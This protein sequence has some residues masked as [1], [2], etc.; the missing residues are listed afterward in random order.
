[1][2]DKDL[3]L[4]IIITTLSIFSLILIVII[5]L[6]SSYR[7]RLKQQIRFSNM[8]LHYEQ[9]LRTVEQEVQ[10]S[11]MNHIS[12]ELHDNIGQLLTLMRVQI[13]KGKKQSDETATALIPISKTLTD[14]TKQIRL[15]SHA[16]NSEYLER[17]GLRETIAQEVIRLQQLDDIVVHFDTDG[18]EPGLSK[19]QC[20]MAFRIFQEMLNNTLKH[21]HAQN[22]YILLE[23]EKHFLLQVRDDGRGFDA[24]GMTPEE[25]GNGLKN[26]QKRARLAGLGF[27]LQSAPGAGCTY[28]IEHPV[29]A[30]NEAP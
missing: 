3:A 4:A 18:T 26:M 17:N 24:T 28:A 12:Q 13:E 20:L 21:A 8:Q 22:I 30:A 14:T 6:F 7:Q 27:S 19:D 11:L 16:L 25:Q 23:G 2:N 15:L 5:T 9:E 29:A 10:E 1:M